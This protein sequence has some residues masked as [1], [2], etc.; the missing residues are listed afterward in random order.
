MMTQDDLK[1][2]VAQAAIEYVPVDSIVGVGTGKVIGKIWSGLIP[3]DAPWPVAFR[4]GC[5][6]LEGFVIGRGGPG[7]I[8]QVDQAGAVVEIRKELLDTAEGGSFFC[9]DLGGDPV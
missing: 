9:S 3:H 1:R 7:I 2:A 8:L 6:Q 5:H 4:Q